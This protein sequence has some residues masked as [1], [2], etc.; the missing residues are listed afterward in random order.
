MI[1][2]RLSRK[3]GELRWSQAMLHRVTKIRTTTISDMYNEF[4]ERV[5]LDY[6]DRICKALDCDLSEI[7][8][9][10]PDEPNDK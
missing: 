3:L 4:S 8:E 10:I 1:R 5:S 7:L 2:I 9:Y 6:L